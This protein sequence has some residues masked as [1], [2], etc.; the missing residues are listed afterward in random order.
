MRCRRRSLGKAWK[1]P[2]AGDFCGGPVGH[3]GLTGLSAIPHSRR[4]DPRV[5]GSG[6]RFRLKIGPC[7]APGARLT[8]LCARRR[9]K[10]AGRVDGHKPSHQRRQSARDGPEFT[11]SAWH[12]NIS[13]A[14]IEGVGFAWI[15]CLDGMACSGPMTTSGRSA[16]GVL[17]FMN[18]MIGS[19]G[20]SGNADV[21]RQDR[22]TINRYSG[23]GQTSNVPLGAARC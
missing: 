18:R 15:K 9:S 8:S 7:R 21:S 11:V 19:L 2:A 13:S 3:M 17:P 4:A 1:T 20:R 23:S 10:Q 12:S 6:P 22:Q 16:R 14:R 5:F